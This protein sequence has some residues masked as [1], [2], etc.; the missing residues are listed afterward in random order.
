MTCYSISPQV[1]STS[2]SSKWDT[3]ILISAGICGPLFLFVIICAIIKIIL[4]ILVS[5]QT[6][7]SLRKL[8]LF[9]YTVSLWLPGLCRGETMEARTEED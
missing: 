1:C 6:M 5:R 8:L 9:D 7:R 2:E 3:K 4:V